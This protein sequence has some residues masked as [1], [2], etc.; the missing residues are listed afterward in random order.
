ME[1]AVFIGGA[2]VQWLRDE[3][4]LIASSAQSEE[5]A[6][7]VP[8]AGGVFV[9][10]AFTGLGSPYWDADVRGAIFGL[11]RGSSRA[12]LTRAALESIAY[13]CCDLVAAMEQDIGE[14]VRAMK[15]D[16]GASA[17]GLLMQF[18]ADV[19]H[20]DIAVPEVAE[21]T[22]LGAAYL[23]GLGAGFW[24]GTAELRA[25]WRE[26]TRYEPRLAEPRRQELLRGW[27]GAVKAARSFSAGS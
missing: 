19:A 7:A 6:R 16:G 8:D 22:A 5:L 1:G 11:T 4:G 25:H 18:Q 10:P 27:R 3:L 17:N 12:H 21:T 23:A 15:A 24:A 20:L 2:V 26:R 14:P 9:V 13:Q